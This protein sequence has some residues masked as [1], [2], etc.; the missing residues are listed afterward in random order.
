MYS[1]ASSLESIE[2]LARSPHRV[3][4]L[5]AIRAEPRT[6]DELRELTDASRVTL[7]RIL[8]DFEER[9]WIVRVDRHYETTSRGA[10]IAAEFT[11]LV[12]NLDALETLPDVLAWFPGE[13]PTF[14]LRLLDDAT[15]I[16][17]DE[18]DLLGPIRRGLDHIKRTDQLEIVANGAAA[19]FIEEL[20]AAVRSGRTNTLLLPPETIEA[21][22]SDPDLRDQVRE[23]L[24][25]GRTT[26]LRYDGGGKLPV[27]Q[28]GDGTVALCSGDHQA[29]IETDDPRVYDWAVSYF[30]SLRT[31]ATPVSEES[32]ANEP[33]VVKSDLVTD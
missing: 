21:L 22:R 15:A 16:K 10:F 29:M 18:S 20:L 14:E 8:T 4:A 11:R 32:F 5:D 30:A 19:E 31:D 1:S 7:G 9:D 6:R 25:S 23:M 2:F 12:S 13:Q 3:V 17:A 28:I 24:G 33:H 26:L 27:F